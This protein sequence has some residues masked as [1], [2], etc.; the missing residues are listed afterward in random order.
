M[1]VMPLRT[2]QLNPGSHVLLRDQIVSHVE[3]AVQARDV[4]P[5]ERLPAVRDLA[6]RWHVGAN[7]ITAAWG[8]L[9]ERRVII[10]VHGK[11][12]FI[13]EQPEPIAQ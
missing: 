13:V 3:A 2:P 11:G 12:T 9:Q 7:T 1:L 4:Q 8:I 6:D 5:G 10:S